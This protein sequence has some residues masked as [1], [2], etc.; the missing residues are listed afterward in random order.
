LIFYRSEWAHRAPTPGGIIF[1]VSDTEWLWYGHGGRNGRSVRLLKNRQC[2]FSAISS[3]CH[4]GLLYFAKVIW[5]INRHFLSVMDRWSTITIMKA[6]PALL[7]A[8]V[9]TAIIAISMFIVGGNA[10][11]NKNSV[12]VLNAPPSS[13]VSDVSDPS[14]SNSTSDPQLTAAQQ[15]IAQMQKLLTQYQAREQQYQTELKQAAQ[16]VND[17]NTQLAQANQQLQVFQQ[18]LMA[19]QQR[20]VIRITQDGQIQLLRGSDD[21]F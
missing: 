5:K 19:L 21:G 3:F 20:G 16:K 2:Q 11:L 9:M 14:S 4:D 10:L 18:V 8:L 1:N 7:F 12:P 15:Q 17:A 13:N 6:F